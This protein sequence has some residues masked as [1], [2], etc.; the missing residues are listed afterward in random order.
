MTDLDYTLVPLTDAAEIG[1]VPPALC[2]H[3]S[4][5]GALPL[6][7]GVVP[8]PHLDMLFKQEPNVVGQGALVRIGKPLERGAHLLGHPHVHRRVPFH[9]RA[10]ARDTWQRKAPRC[11]AILHDDMRCEA[12]VNERLGARTWAIVFPGR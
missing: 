1:S 6:R 12:L 11:T 2:W 7:G 9:R 4:R 5:C 8:L 3:R 10:V